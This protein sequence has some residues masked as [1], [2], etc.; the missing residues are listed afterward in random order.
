[1]LLPTFKGEASEEL[2]RQ[3]EQSD[4][5]IQN[6]ELALSEALDVDEEEQILKLEAEL[7]VVQKNQAELKGSIQTGEDNIVLIK[8][9][10][11]QLQGEAEVNKALYEEGEAVRYISKEEG[12]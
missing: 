4:L 11:I 8:K 5:Q 3:I 12:D 7:S 10:L 9:E 2:I 6:A 1:M